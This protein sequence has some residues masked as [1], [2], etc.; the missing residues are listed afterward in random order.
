MCRRQ[1]MASQ[2]TAEYAW[3]ASSRGMSAIGSPA[4]PPAVDRPLSTA[5]GGS[6]VAGRPGAGITEPPIMFTVR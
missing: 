1:W 5:V 3:A 2:L 4:P 6:A